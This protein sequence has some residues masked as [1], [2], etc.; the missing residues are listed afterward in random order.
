M[1]DWTIITRSLRARLFSTITT[2]VM[3][4]VGV[5]LMVVLL[6]MRQAGRRSFERGTGNVHLLISRDASALASVLNGLFY[7]SPPARPLLWTEFERIPKTVPLEWAVPAQLGDSYRGRWPV[8]ATTPE[9]FSRFQPAEDARWEIAEGRLFERNFEIVL[10]WQAAR[11]TDLQRGDTITLTH[12]TSAS[13]AG[14]IHEHDK[15]RFTVVGILRPTGTAHDRAMFIN[16]SSAWLLH[17]LDRIERTGDEVHQSHENDGHDH[18]EFPVCEDDLTDDDRKIT[19]ILARVPTRPGS[20]VSASMPVIAERLRRDPVF[21]GAPLTIANPRAEIQRL[22]DIV[23]NVDVILRAM[24]AVVM[25]ASGVGIMLALYNSMEQR[26]RQVAIMRVLG[27]SRVRVFAL[28]MT[29][30][31]IVGLIGAGLGLGVGLIGS[32]IAAGVLR[33]EAGVVVMP[34]LTFD[35]AFLLVTGTLLLACAAGVMPAQL[36]YRTSVAEHLRPFA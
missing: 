2:I 3:V 21:Q 28:V 27:A 36:A 16:L 35:D 17:A 18:A 33:T 8:L 24:A 9:F 29:E 23:G 34:V 1:T 30:S 26:R 4:G 22:L 31:A 11:G 19:N 25:L 20:D 10:G 12:G 5:G 32:S 15:G 13:R 7:A 6:S 14:P